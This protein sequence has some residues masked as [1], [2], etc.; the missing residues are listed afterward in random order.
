MSEWVAELSHTLSSSHTTAAD[1]HSHKPRVIGDDVDKDF[2]DYYY[3]LAAAAAR[4]PGAGDRAFA[5]YVKYTLRTCAWTRPTTNV[6]LSLCQHLT[7]IFGK[8]DPLVPATF[9]EVVFKV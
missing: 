4:R 6:L 1:V 2:L 8:N 9:G 3:Q 7:L 5:R